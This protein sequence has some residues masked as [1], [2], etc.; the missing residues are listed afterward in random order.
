MSKMTAAAKTRAACMYAMYR[1]GT[2][3]Q[4]IGNKFQIT[5]E[6]TRQILQR[7]YGVTGKDGGAHQRYSAK[8]SARLAQ[9]DQECLAQW[10]MTYNAR[11]K[12]RIAS[13]AKMA[14]G[15]NRETTIIGAFRRQKQN[16]RL[17]GI[18]WRLTLGQWW[19]IWEESG[20]WDMRGRNAGQY[21]MGRLKDEGAYAVGNVQI[22]LCSD[23]SR[24]ARMN[25]PNVRRQKDAQG[26]YFLNP[27][28]SRPWVA[29]AH[30]KFIGS[31][32]TDEEALAA[33]RSYL[34]QRA[35]A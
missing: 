8:Q 30:R 22:L 29:K 25:K 19:S 24:L 14:E 9:K 26:V 21:V 32:R 10:G 1:Q 33:R 20:K 16:A 27:G 13:R 15:A 31:F 7:V 23:N 12:L 2:T 17:R 5:R 35:A 11:E 3:L 6:R 18:E 28:S 4:E 34:I